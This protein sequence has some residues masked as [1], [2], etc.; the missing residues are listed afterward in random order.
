MIILNGE[1]SQAQSYGTMV[2]NEDLSHNFI[3][4][5]LIVKLVQMKQ[6]A[7]SPWLSFL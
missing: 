4:Y 3:W 2:P 1:L 5:S 7:L 6:L